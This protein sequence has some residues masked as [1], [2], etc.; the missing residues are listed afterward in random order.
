LLL[1]LLL[2]LVVAVVVLAVIIIIIIII[3]VI[4]VVVV[5]V[6]VVVEIVVVTVVV[7]A[8][9]VLVTLAPPPPSQVRSHPLPTL[10]LSTQPH[11]PLS[12]H[13][14]TI[15]N[16]I[17]NLTVDN[18]HYTTVRLSQLAIGTFPSALAFLR[19]QSR[20]ALCGWPS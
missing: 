11:A 7:A 14:I 16:A 18:Q 9:A 12:Y 15:L 2:L 1:L 13:I 6:V 17:K 10:H 8:V 5:V 4:L 19:P 20:A 3:D